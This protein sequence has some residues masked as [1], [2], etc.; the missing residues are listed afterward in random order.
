MKLRLPFLLA[1]YGTARLAEYPRLTLYYDE[2][3]PIGRRHIAGV[4]DSWGPTAPV[5]T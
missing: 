2:R 3:L 5:H 1:L 4:I